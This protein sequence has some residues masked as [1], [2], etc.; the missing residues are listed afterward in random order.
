MDPSRHPMIRRLVAEA[1]LKAQAPE[2]YAAAVKAQAAA[3]KAWRDAA[4][5]AKVTLPEDSGD[6]L[7]QLREK[8]PAEY[9][10]LLK[11]AGS[12]PQTALLKLREAAEKAGVKLMMMFRGGPNGGRRPGADREAPEAGSRRTSR[13]PIAKLRQAFPQEMAQYDEW[14]KSD[15]EKARELLRDLIRRMG[16]PERRD[17]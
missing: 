12:D 16:K 8:A 11:L 14:K 6:Q 13:V 10:E 17:R 5:K 9:E 7:Q 15:P 4:A 3:A 1:Q 2:E